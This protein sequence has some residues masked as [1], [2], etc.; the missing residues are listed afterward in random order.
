MRLRRLPQKASL[1]D[2]WTSNPTPSYSVPV[3]HDELRSI[4][5]NIADSFAD[6]LGFPIGYYPTDV[7]G[8][9]GKS[10]DGFVTVDFLRGAIV[11]GVRVRFARKSRWSLPRRVSGFVGKAR[12]FR[13]KL[14]NAD[15][16]LFH[17]G[18]P[19]DGGRYDR[20]QQWAPF[21]GRIRRRASAAS[22]DRRH[23][24]EGAHA[25]QTATGVKTAPRAWFSDAVTGH[26]SSADNGRRFYPTRYQAVGLLR[27]LRKV[28]DGSVYVF[29]VQVHGFALVERG[30]GDFEFGGDHPV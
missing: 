6:G 28:Y 3:K 19:K 18:A 7:F 8:E 15:R 4:A 1:S 11:A 22:K 9:A 29:D 10:P 25:S 21:S 13:R 20:R 30:D 26:R 14:P 2:I 27:H 17:S 12:W 23:C 24:W 16:P 5:H